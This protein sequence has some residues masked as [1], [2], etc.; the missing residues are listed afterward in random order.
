MQ[1]LDELIATAKRL[2]TG[3]KGLLAMDESTNSIHRRFA[4]VGIPR[5]VENRRAYRQMIV[6][7]PGI[8]E[9]LSGAILVEETVH[10]STDEGVPF[11]AILQD[12][13]ILPGIKVD[14]GTI[15]LAGF[16]QE[17]ITVGLDGLRERLREYHKMGLRFAKWRAVISIGPDTP[18]E[19]AIVANMHELARYAAFCQEAGILP[20]VEPEVLMDGDHGIDR[21]A[22]ITR[23]VLHQ[24]FHQLNLQ[25][26][27]LRCLL[28][29]PNM[30]ISGLGAAR[31]AGIR[32][33]AEAT[34]ECL[35]ECVPAAVPGIAFLSGGQSPE[36]ATAHLNAIK[37]LDP[38]LPWAVTFSYSRAIQQPALELWAGQ[39]EN[40]IAAQ[41]VLFRRLQLLSLA[42]RG[43]YRPA[44]EDGSRD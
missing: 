4:R 7:T 23:R 32:E 31:Q 41:E 18:T 11:L 43:I 2:M 3:D 44:L 25:Q 38:G 42:R 12:A 26:V 29:K 20:I 19:G 33:V 14:E 8:G 9:F 40:T 27:H 1:H 36:K 30:I 13:G 21:C 39:Y 35:M 24:L 17:K 15:D 28:L 37:S 22:E 5:T 34:V 16:P 6:T 10:E